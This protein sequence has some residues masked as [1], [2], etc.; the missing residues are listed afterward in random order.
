MMTVCPV[1]GKL[2]VVH[3]PEFWVYR[4][5]EH[6]LCSENCMMIF[7]TR[8]FKERTGWI[9]AHYRK[10][11]EGGKVASKVT[12]E[13]K[14]KAVEIAIGGGN[15]LPYLKQ[16]GSERPDALWWTIKQNLKKVDPVKY[17]MLPDRVNAKKEEQEAELTVRH[18]D[19]DEIQKAANESVGN[20]AVEAAMENIREIMARQE[21]MPVT[22]PVNY[23]GFEVMAVKSP[24]TGFRFEYD[25]R[26]GLVTWRTTEGDEV[27]KTQEEWHRMAEELPK[28][29]QIFG[30]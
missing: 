19:L 24:E 15:P 5:R 13:Q 1:C 25:S 11:K 8:E 16:C 10:K 12:L 18:E 20:A 21:R 26:Y 7:D 28:A 30:I 29:L 2:M 17:A 23:D 9:E 4:R 3:W 14:K 22:R 27:T 6:Y